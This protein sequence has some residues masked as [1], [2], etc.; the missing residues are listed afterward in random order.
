[1]HDLERQCVVEDTTILYN[2]LQHTAICC[3]TLHHLQFFDTSDMNHL[4]RAELLHALSLS[5][6]V[7]VT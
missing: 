2:A 1:M 7:S 4:Q 5:V 3:N 6:S